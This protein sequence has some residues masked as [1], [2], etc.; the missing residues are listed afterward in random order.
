VS[1]SSPERC[2]VVGAPVSYGVGIFKDRRRQLEQILGWLADPATR[3]VTVFGRRG[4]G[5]SALVAKVVDTLAADGS[6]RGIV[7]LSTRSEG[8]ARSEG[9]IAIERI[10]FTCAEVAEP[11]ELE[12]LDTIWASQRARS[13]KLIRLFEILGD[14]LNLIVLDNIEDQLTD[15]GRPVGRDLEIFLDVIFRL[16]HGPRLLVT[17]QVPIAL[18]PALR[19]MQARLHLRDGLPVPES[20]ALLRELDRDGEAGLLNA[21]DA[22]L[23]NAARWLH[24]LP[25]ALEL[26]VGTMTA[27]DLTLPTFDDVLRGF[28]TRG[29]IV[30]QLAQGRYNRLD[31]QTR[32]V[33]DALA[34]FRSPVQREPVEW[35]IAPLAPHIDVARAL[36]EL[37]HVYMVSVD[38]RT[39][40][41][42][43]HP[44]D[45]DLVYAALPAGGPF[46]RQVL[47]RRVAAWYEHTR[48]LP[49][50]DSIADVANQRT[51][52][53]HRL[54]AEDYNACAFILDDISEFLALQ[55]SGRAVV[56]MHFALEG[57]LT[58]DASILAD[59]VSF[60]IA[61]HIGGPYQEAIEPL[62]RAVQLADQLG[63]LPHLARALFSLGDILRYL[64]QLP[65]AI[66]VIERAAEVAGQLGDVVHQA[67]ALLCLSLSHSY[68]GQLPE[69][70]A[71]ADQISA[72]AEE[73]GLPVV[74]GRAGD[75]RSLASLIVGRWDDAYEAGAQALRAYQEAG[76]SEALGYARNVQGIALIAMGR[77]ADAI[78]YLEQA[79]NYSVGAETPRAEGLCSYNLAWAHWLAGDYA[80]AEEAARGAVQAF[81]RAGGGD[82]DASEHLAAA[83]GALRAGDKAAAS[84]ALT[85]AAEAARGN[86]D[87]VPTDWLLDAAARLEADTDQ[88]ADA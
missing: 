1:T 76:M 23:A 24:G 54:R 14:R 47:E 20:V 61:R 58:D 57:H 19:P 51:A 43:L 70:F 69:A 88:A 67:H 73:S 36:S 8:A 52:F 77:V 45:A 27:D 62:R 25:R 59:L 40:E 44:T 9:A 78:G 66:E 64:R 32:L 80:A 33:F 81:R 84:A 63:D 34:V 17:S 46:S 60:G 22:E 18:D 74:A 6:C 21:T 68:L 42:A 53:E 16:P 31:E 7:N 56:G 37:N 5:K 65:E 41:F 35:V 49:P 82:I 72:L 83:M 3:M 15:S 55:G 79:M 75:A 11:A 85:A 50:W 39:R 87:L 10:F 38:R 13:D 71:V 28:T 12:T 26:A 2:R 29:D 30:D 4:I 86:S 48:K